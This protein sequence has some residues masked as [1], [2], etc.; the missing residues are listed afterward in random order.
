MIDFN[1]DW[2]EPDIWAT[3]THSPLSTIPPTASNSNHPNPPPVKFDSP[4]STPIPESPISSDESFHPVQ[5]EVTNPDSNSDDQGPSTPIAPSS[6]LKLASYLE[7]PPQAHLTSQLEP[8]SNDPKYSPPPLATTSWSAHQHASTLET[9]P[10]QDFF[11]PSSSSAFDSDIGFGDFNS[12]QEYSTH[13]HGHDDDEF[14]DFDDGEMA[15]AD[16]SF[17]GFT[18]SS[19]L[20]MAVP[21]RPVVPL[22]LPQQFSEDAFRVALEPSLKALFEESDS[23]CCWFEPPVS[24]REKAKAEQRSNSQSKQKPS[25]LK[26]EDLQRT[27]GT[28]VDGGDGLGRPAEWKRSQIRRLHLVHLGIPVDLNDFLAPQPLARRLL[29]IDTKGADSNGN[30]KACQSPSLGSPFRG[31][32]LDRKRCQELAATSQDNLSTQDL[33]QLTSLRDELKSL[34]QQAS[35]SLTLKKQQ[36][37]QSIQDCKSYNTMI[38]DLVL[39]AQKIQMASPGSTKRASSINLG[40][41]SISSSSSKWSSLTGGGSG[42]HHRLPGQ[43]HQLGSVDSKSGAPHSKPGPANSSSKRFSLNQNP[44]P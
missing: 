43:T 24:V 21:I 2:D 44:H 30:S 31:P 28:L 6:P 25:I 29:S 15:A 5:T 9:L 12:H 7:S 35:E 37:D 36:R 27:W 19:P 32:M 20:P 33:G 17:G 18:V 38:S 40:S 11:G 22:I 1:T 34:I 41:S 42:H 8:S 13:D 23:S 14:G 16:D 4:S 39:A 3:P 10:G 26:S